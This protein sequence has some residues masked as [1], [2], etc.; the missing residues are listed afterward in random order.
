[1]G[2]TADN[3]ENNATLIRELEVL[4]PTW[5]GRTMRVRCFGHVLNLIVRVRMQTLR[6]NAMLTDSLSG[7]PLTAYVQ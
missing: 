5:P 7:Y 1:M 2:F 6:Q 3:A 4:I